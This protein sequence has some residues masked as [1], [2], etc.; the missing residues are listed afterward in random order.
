MTR[1]KVIRL[2][3]VL[4][5]F[6]K[7]YAVHYNSHS[8]HVQK[9]S[10]LVICIWYLKNIQEEKIFEWLRHS[11]ITFQISVGFLY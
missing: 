4:L 3:F 5:G 7:L 9:S 2:K 8:T 6:N 1:F 11:L 10:W